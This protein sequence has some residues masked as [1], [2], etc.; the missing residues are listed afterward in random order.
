MG[1][2]G[3]SSGVSVKGN[4][5]GTQNKTLFEKDG[6]KFVVGVNNNSEAIV[7]TMTPN[8]IYALVNRNNNNLKSIL[9]F[10]NGTNRT[11]RIDL[12]HFHDKTKPH[13]HDGKYEG[14]FRNKFTNEELAMIDKISGLWNAYKSKL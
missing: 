8:R 5:Y 11:K 14:S 9:Y 2:R 1:G 12:D 13:A 4:L 3:A 7:E 6:I 10:E